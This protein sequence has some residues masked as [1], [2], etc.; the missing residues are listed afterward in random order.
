M[1][2]LIERGEKIKKLIKE[3]EQEYIAYYHEAKQYGMS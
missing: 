2:Y 1:T 3:L